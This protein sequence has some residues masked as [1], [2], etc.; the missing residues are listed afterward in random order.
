MRICG[1]AAVVVLFV[2]TLLHSALAQPVVSKGVLFTRTGYSLYTFDND[3]VGSGA[4]VCNPPCSN[5]FPP[6]LATGKDAA[7]GDFTLISRQDGGK[8]WAY[9]GQP[10]YRFYADDKPGDH[11]GDGMN[12]N[13][14]HVARE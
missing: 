3:V 10:L 8:Q 1:V 2:A 6:Y 13:L 14:W 7:K 4:S 11:G 9:R 12:R 5:I